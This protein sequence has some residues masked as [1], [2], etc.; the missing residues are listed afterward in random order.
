MAKK[1]AVKKPAVLGEPQ[2]PKDGTTSAKIWAIADRFK[3]DRQRTIKDA[4][5]KGYN[6]ATVITQYGRWRN[7]TGYVRPKAVKADKPAKKGPP[8]KKAV[9]KGPPKKVA[10]V[11]SINETAPA[12]T[13]T[14]AE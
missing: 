8:A 6:E 11:V 2:R 12:V 10:P 9:K 14:S 4:V 7:Y 1:K 3:G 13:S 5:G